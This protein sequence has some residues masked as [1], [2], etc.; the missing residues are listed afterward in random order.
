[1]RIVAVL[2]LDD[3]GAAVVPGTSLAPLLA[4]VLDALFGTALIISV[5]EPASSDIWAR[6]AASSSSLTDS[7]SYSS[8]TA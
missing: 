8:G 7:I 4:A 6:G 5:R 3:C 1:L 2:V